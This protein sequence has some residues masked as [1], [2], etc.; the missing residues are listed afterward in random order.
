MS[1]VD[2]VLMGS[3]HEIRFAYG[4]VA[5]GLYSDMRRWAVKNFFN[6]QFKFMKNL[7]VIKQTTLNTF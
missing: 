4:S 6:S 5:V 7:K 2:S 3:F 1:R